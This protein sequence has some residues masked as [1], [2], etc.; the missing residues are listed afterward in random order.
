MSLCAVCDRKSTNRS[1]RNW[2]TPSAGLAMSSKTAEPI[3]GGPRKPARWW[4][5]ITFRVTLLYTL[6]VAAIL[7]I[8]GVLLDWALTRSIEQLAGQFLQDEIH[9][10]RRAL[11]ELPHYP[12]ALDAEV[13][14]D[15]PHPNYYA[16]VLDEHGLPLAETAGIDEV[17][18]S[19]AFPLPVAATEAPHQF[20]KVQG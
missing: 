5:S 8:S 17:F 3:P 15:S 16:R 9:D 1:R 19:I 12:G 11:R 2:S 14:S 7:A 10:M 6:L 4:S 20:P 18:G 13:T